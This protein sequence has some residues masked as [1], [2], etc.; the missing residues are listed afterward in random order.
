LIPGVR[1]SAADFAQAVEE[2]LAEGKLIEVWL[3]QVD[4]RDASHLLMIP[5][6]SEALRRPVARARGTPEVLE[7]EPWY[8]G[9][10]G[11]ESRQGRAKGGPRR[12]EP[13]G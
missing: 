3:Q 13:G 11:A 7:A 9:L 10:S 8:A 1:V 12:Y 4:D 5:G 6:L 2:L